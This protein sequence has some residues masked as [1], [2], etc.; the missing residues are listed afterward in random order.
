M[1]WQ[2]AVMRWLTALI[3]CWTAAA[4]A[5]TTD[6]S[7]PDSAYLRYAAG[8]APYTAEVSGLE[9]EGGRMFRASGV[10]IADRYVL[11][12]AH[13]AAPAGTCIVTFG[14][15]NLRVSRVYVHHEWEPGRL[16]HDD[17]ALLETADSIGLAWY[18]PLSD[19]SEEPGSVCSIA[20]Y[21]VSGPIS[22]GYS[23]SDGRLRAGTNTVA[24]FERGVI[25]CLISRGSSPMEF[26]IGPG[27]SGGPLFVNGRLAGINSFTMADAP[28]L[29]SKSGE[30][31]GHTRVS[32]H[33][34]W[35][36]GIVG[37]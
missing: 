9:A 21:G 6:D 28:P 5:G 24:R 25:V 18:P 29:R 17:I 13:V 36:E 31:S 4:L 19:G 8:F 27:D 15:R 30:E 37:R 10:A 12:A 14:E 2:I 22:T 20:G 33:R 23:V 16:G 11:T 32:L 35:I 3:V 26:G 1:A 34:E 7:I